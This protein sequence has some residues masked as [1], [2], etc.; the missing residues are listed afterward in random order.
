MLNVLDLSKSFLKIKCK[1]TKANGQ[2]LPEVDK[3]SAINYPVFSFFSEV[4]I[5]LGGKFM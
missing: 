2:N 1:I 3:V 5:I 4:D